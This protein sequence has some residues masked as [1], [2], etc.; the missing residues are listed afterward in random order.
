M[1]IDIKGAETLLTTPL[2]EAIMDI[3]RER[4]LLH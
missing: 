2:I 3:V 1:K 4:P